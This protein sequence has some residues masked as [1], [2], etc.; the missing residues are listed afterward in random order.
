[1]PFQMQVAGDLRKIDA[2][3]QHGKAKLREIERQT[4]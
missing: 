1:M 2:S 4:L 3:I